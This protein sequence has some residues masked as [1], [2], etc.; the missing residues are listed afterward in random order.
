MYAIKEALGQSSVAVAEIYLAG[1]G[2]LR[3]VGCLPCWAAIE[4]SIG[5]A[6]FQQSYDFFFTTLT[7]V[8]FIMPILNVV[9]LIP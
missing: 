9:R 7:V 3:A 2:A 6:C 1:L 5:K 8:I 4:W